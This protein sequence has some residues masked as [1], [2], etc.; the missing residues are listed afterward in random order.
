MCSVE[1]TVVKNGDAADIQR[2]SFVDQRFHTAPGNTQY[3]HI[4]GFR[5]I[6]HTGI[7]GDTLD[8]FVTGIY[9]I[10]LPLKTAVM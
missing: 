3:S 10:N 8:F 2:Y 6:A 1:L 4:N 5:Y 9:Q 7:A